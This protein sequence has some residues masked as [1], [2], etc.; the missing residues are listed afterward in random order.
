M[1]QLWWRQWL[2]NH[3]YLQLVHTYADERSKTTPSARVGRISNLS[4]SPVFYKYS[5]RSYIADS[6]SGHQLETKIMLSQDIMVAS[7]CALMLNCGTVL[8]CMFIKF[9]TRRVVNRW[10][11]MTRF[12]ECKPNSVEVMGNI[13]IF[14]FI[15]GL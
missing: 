14:C 9:A 11:V 12:S 7:V 6:A 3:K 13:T 5:I 2:H 15:E 4:I 1:T 10:S 8:Q